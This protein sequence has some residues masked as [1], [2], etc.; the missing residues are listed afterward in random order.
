MTRVD[1]LRGIHGVFNGSIRVH[2]DE[3]FPRRSLAYGVVQVCCDKDERIV[4]VDGV[5]VRRLEGSD[6]LRRYVRL[7]R[8]PKGNRDKIIGLIDID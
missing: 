2:P 4:P 3:R 7:E 8:G 5:S 6:D 1:D